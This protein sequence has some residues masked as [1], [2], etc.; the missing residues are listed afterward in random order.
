MKLCTGPLLNWYWRVMDPN[1]P[2]KHCRRVKINLKTKYSLAEGNVVLTPIIADGDRENIFGD[3]EKKADMVCGLLKIPPP[4]WR[5]RCTVVLFPVVE[6]YN[7]P[8]SLNQGRNP[9][10]ILEAAS[11]SLPSVVRPSAIVL[12]KTLGGHITGMGRYNLTRMGIYDSITSNL[13]SSWETMAPWPFFRCTFGL[14]PM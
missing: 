11:L 1:K 2:P 3:R 12:F 14:Q 7:I 10:W 8:G 13:P 9:P 4:R 6:A 5:W